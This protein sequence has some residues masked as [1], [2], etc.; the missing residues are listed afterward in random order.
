MEDKDEK[1][2]EQDEKK[3]TVT[4]RAEAAG[5]AAANPAD[6]PTA[7]PVEQG[8]SNGNQANEPPRH[9]QWAGQ[10]P[11]QPVLPPGYAIDPLSGQVVV[12]GQAAPQYQFMYGGVNPVQAQA[13][14]QAQAYYASAFAQQKTPFQ[15]ETAEHM[16][17]R[18]AEEQQRQGQIVRSFEQFVEGDATVSD[19]VRTLYTNTSQNDQ[20]WK[21][22]LVGAAATILLT[23]K[24]AR[25]ALGKTFGSLFGGTQGELKSPAGQPEA[26]Q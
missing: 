6:N 8:R 16:A 26:G 21:G 23:S 4:S 13:Q 5:Q 11:E 1:E 20:L 22:V 9:H 3:K 14:A 24:P 7:N 12:T 18:L 25:T 19:V 15:A 2:H 17:A 10:A